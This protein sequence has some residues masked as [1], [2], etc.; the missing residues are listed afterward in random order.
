MSSSKATGRKE[1]ILIK[2]SM[3][4]KKEITEFMTFNPKESLLTVS[5]IFGE[6]YGRPISKQAIWRTKQNREKYITAPET[7]NDRKRIRSANSEQFDNALY[8]QINKQLES[9]P[10]SYES[11]KLLAM[12][13][14]KLEI[15]AHNKEVQQLR[16]SRKWWQFFMKLRGIRY[17]KIVGSKK[18]LEPGAVEKERS[19]LLTI[20][21][22]YRP[23][24]SFNYDESAV[25]TEFK[26]YYS[27]HTTEMDGKINK[28]DE[29]KRLTMGAFISMSGEVLM[30][31]FV[32]KNFNRSFSKLSV[33]A[34]Q[35][36][37]FTHVK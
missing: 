1:P 27:I 36:L 11:V 7:E 8:D 14:Q 33:N 28:G 18:R 22:K 10:L 12:K 3:K 5:Q 13:I 31:M 25:L 4:E 16:F 17:R 21:S 34:K 37:L 32:G 24:V 2:L 29:K 35:D 15:Y 6:K 9:T 23:E 30:P 26:G 19:R 20:L